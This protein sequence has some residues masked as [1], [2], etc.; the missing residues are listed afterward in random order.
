MAVYRMRNRAQNYD[1]GS[2]W[3]VP[4]LQTADGES[5]SPTEEPVA[6][7][8]MGTHP[9]GPSSVEI[10]SRDTVL[11]SEILSRSGSGEL[12]YLFK[13]LTAERGLSIQTHPTQAMA[14]D[15]FAWEESQ[16]IDIA[17]PHRTYR[18]R[19]HKPELLCAVDEFW[20]L[21][22]FR[23]LSELQRE[24]RGLAEMLTEEA[25]EADKA[26]EA[27]RAEEAVNQL[28]EVLQRFVADPGVAVWR[29]VF[30]TLLRIAES[31]ETTAVER[32]LHAYC[33]DDG[34]GD[35]RPGDSAAADDPPD[36]NNRYWWCRELM[37]Q[38][39]GDLG[40]AA[41]LYLN[42]IHLRPGEAVFLE[43]GVLHAYLYGAGV[44][45]MASSDNVLRA[46]CTSKH[47]D[48]PELLRTVQ[49]TFDP[50]AVVE[51]DTVTCGDGT[52]L[53]YRTGAQEFELVRFSLSSKPEGP[54][55]PAGPGSPDSTDGAALGGHPLGGGMTFAKRGG[56]AIVLAVGG[57][58]EVT[59]MPS[60]SPRD[61]AGGIADSV[62]PVVLHSTESALVDYETQRVSLRGRSAATVYVAGT[63]GTIICAG[64][65]AS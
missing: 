25:G 13:I 29:E 17:A 48:R 49:F 65:A 39:P 47:V 34:S 42:L 4:A 57:A 46:G 6:E 62:G 44:E 3:M 1:W 2:R 22:G 50:P 58:V 61:P 31:G 33:S 10:D 36:R 8:W 12:P 24:M 30:A 32:A 41:P 19:N 9:R 11:L 7:I 5:L 54:Q 59:A 55:K 40:A 38:F 35:R 53:R 56:A 15:G 23:P 43:A 52:L 26:E 45:L 27:D 60:E 63:P 18:D 28:R 37:R 21:R 20:G 14:R 51:P 16:G 64:D